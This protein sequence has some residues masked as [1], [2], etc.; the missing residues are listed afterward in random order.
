MEQVTNLLPQ[1]RQTATTNP[2]QPPLVSKGRSE[3][4]MPLLTKEGLGVVD[5]E[6]SG[7]CL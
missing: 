3:N 6:L 5:S 1:Q 7:L 4:K 2:S